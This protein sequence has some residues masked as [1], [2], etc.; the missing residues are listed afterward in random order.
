[1]LGMIPLRAMHFLFPSLDLTSW[2]GI[3]VD[4]GHV[5]HFHN[6]DCKNTEYYVDDISKYISFSLL[7]H[8]TKQHAFLYYIVMS[9]GL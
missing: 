2:W 9:T 1:M 5:V 6:F 4:G 7:K 3:M 8:Y